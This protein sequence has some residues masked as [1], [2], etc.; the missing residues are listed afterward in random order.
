[1]KKLPV[2]SKSAKTKKKSAATPKKKQQK[3][4]SD[5]CAECPVEIFS[6]ELTPK[7]DEDLKI[8]EMKNL[9]SEASTCLETDNTFV[10]NGGDDHRE[11]TKGTVR[12][13][14]GIH[15]I[16]TGPCSW[17]ECLEVVICVHNKDTC[18]FHTTVRTDIDGFE[19]YLESVFA[20]TKEVADAEFKRTE[21]HPERKFKDV[22]DWAKH[23]LKESLGLIKKIDPA[24]FVHDFFPISKFREILPIVRGKDSGFDIKESEHADALVD[25]ID[26]ILDDEQSGGKMLRKLC[27][28]D[29]EIG[30][31]NFLRNFVLPL[32]SENLEWSEYGL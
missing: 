27:G 28:K 18:V 1:M 15:H 26:D 21:Q 7:R 22:D 3:K 4:A 17:E 14:A 30:D 5:A 23:A 20:K 9:L 8:Q 12:V 2:F 19:N 16:P 13:F 29:Y 31:V 6:V 25:L 10:S 11:W 32:V 24:E